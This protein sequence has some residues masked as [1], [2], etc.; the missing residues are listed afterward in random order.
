M[1]A[2]SEA[3]QNLPP[4]RSGGDTTPR[5]LERPQPPELLRFLAG[6][7]LPTISTFR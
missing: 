6:W 4:G 2:A 7:G 5:K 1:T 3:A